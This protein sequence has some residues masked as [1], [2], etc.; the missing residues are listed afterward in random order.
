MKG[1]Y[2]VYKGSLPSLQ[3]FSEK[4]GTLIDLLNNVKT[5]VS[6][7]KLLQ[8]LETSPDFDV[9]YTVEDLVK[10]T[11]SKSVTEL[12]KMLHKSGVPD[13]RDLNSKKE[14]FDALRKIKT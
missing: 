14:V 8:E 4:S 10:I 5:P 11:A 1:S 3:R 13:T 7:L 9:K 2:A 6:D 12:K